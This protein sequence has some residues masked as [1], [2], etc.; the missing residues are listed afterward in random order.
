MTVYITD[1]EGQ[2]IQR[3]SKQEGLQN[4]NVLSIFL[5]KQS[6]LW[7]GLDNGIDF[8]AYNS[9]IKRITPNGQDGSGYTSLIYDKHLY[10][11][12][13]GGLFNVALQQ[14]E[15]LSF[16]KGDFQL[17]SN[18][19]GQSWAMSEINGQLLLGHHEGPFIVNGNSASA[20]ATNEGGFWNF[21]PMSAVYPTAR[22]IAGN[23]KGLSFLDADGN[24][25]KLAERIPD[26]Q[27]SS[28]FVVL[29]RFDNIWVS[30]PYHGVYKISEVTPGKF[31]TKL[32]T[33]ANGLPA[34]LN[35]HVYKLKNELVV[36]TEKGVYIY[37]SSNDRFE[38]SPFYGRLLGNQSLRYLKEDA[39][40]ISGLFTK[41]AGHP[42]YDRQG[43]NSDTHAGADEQ[44]GQRI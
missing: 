25:F 30:H 12:T 19:T 4:N 27:E 5:D 16:S 2:L 10:A 18:T 37:N 3:F 17:V 38:P 9:A 1:H 15:D 28:R 36:A 23:Y 39:G 24:G 43:Y 20:I 6:N 44:T 32:Y 40:E 8:I 7:L 11:G 26:F 22:V 31:T 14:T 35:N 13:S 33:A 21:T 29:D 41:I 34:T 42:G